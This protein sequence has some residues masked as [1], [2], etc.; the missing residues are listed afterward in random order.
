MS[1]GAYVFLCVSIYSLGLN[2]IGV[3]GAVAMSVAM[4]AMINLQE[5]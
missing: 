3:E 4:K 2:S 5:L 1:H